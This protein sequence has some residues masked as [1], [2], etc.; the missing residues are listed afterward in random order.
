MKGTFAKDHLHYKKGETVDANKGIGNYW[1]KTGVWEKQDSKSN[2]FDE[3]T[4]RRQ[5]SKMNKP[6]ME[7]ILGSYN[8][9]LFLYTNK[10]QRIDAIIEL[11]KPIELDEEE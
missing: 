5:L 10:K 9:D 1:L 8:V 4:R 11:E 2:E 3:T 6:E 7:V